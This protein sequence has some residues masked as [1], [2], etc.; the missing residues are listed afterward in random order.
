MGCGWCDHG[1]HGERD[2]SDVAVLLD[3]CAI[4]TLTLLPPQ[5]PAFIPDVTALATLFSSPVVTN[6]AWV[7]LLLLDFY[8][9]RCG[10][11]VGRVRAG[12]AVIQQRTSIWL[13]M[14]AWVHLLLLGIYRRRY[15]QQGA[16]SAIMA[17][18][19]SRSNYP[20]DAHI[21]RAVLVHGIG[22][23][24]PTGHTIT[25][26]LLFGPLILAPILCCLPACAVGLFW[27]MA[28]SALFPLATA[29]SSA[30]SSAPWAS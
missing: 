12:L 28:L 13:C 11:V 16:V 20:A 22:C 24:V 27:W 2:G 29:S 21:C 3:A 30:S 1:A 15:V 9:A 8:Q 4:L 7:H 18:R 6:L 19:P 10:Q 14:A 5:P 26:H 25:P 23:A 17:P